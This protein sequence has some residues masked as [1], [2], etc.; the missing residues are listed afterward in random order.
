MDWC[1]QGIRNFLLYATKVLHKNYV[2]FLIFAWILK[3]LKTHQNII[4]RNLSVMMVLI[5][6]FFIATSHVF[7]VPKQ[8]DII[9]LT[10]NSIFKRKSEKFSV[11]PQQQHLHHRPDKSTLEN[12]KTVSDAIKSM[13]SLFIIL[14]LVVLVGRSRP[15]YY[16]YNKNNAYLPRYTF[17]SLGIIKI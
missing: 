5:V 9:H 12:K 17:L 3:M 8:T 15:I 4:V 13:V 7:F 11:A 10:G 2:I 16:T 1:G 14:F 6:Y